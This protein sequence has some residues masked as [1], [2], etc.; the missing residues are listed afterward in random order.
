MIC[1]FFTLHKEISLLILKSQSQSQSQNRTYCLHIEN[2]Y[3]VSFVCQTHFCI[4]QISDC[5]KGITYWH[6]FYL[7]HVIIVKDCKK[8]S[9]EK[10]TYWFVSELKLFNL[11]FVVSQHFFWSSI[12]GKLQV[13]ESTSRIWLQCRANGWCSPSPRHCLFFNLEVSLIL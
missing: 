1:I 2:S 4:V 8:H 6:F 7:W 10:W 11:L 3:C 5:G 13:V 9:T 12:P